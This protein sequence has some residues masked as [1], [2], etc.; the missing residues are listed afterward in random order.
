MGKPLN[1]LDMGVF[2]DDER[3]PKDIT[4]IDY[5]GLDKWTVSVVR[6]YAEFCKEIGDMYQRGDFPSYISLDN[7]IQDFSR[8]KD[9]EL[10]GYD[11]AKWLVSFCFDKEIKLPKIF[12]HSQNNIARDNIIAYIVNYLNFVE[13]KVIYDSR[14]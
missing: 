1:I 8:G 14:Y 10:T 12:V 9:K 7:D 13:K 2:L 6:S 11:V 3:W 5:K 4:W